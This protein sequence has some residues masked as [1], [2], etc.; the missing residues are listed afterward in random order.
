MV[1]TAAKITIDK[2]ILF[3]YQVVLSLNDPAPTNGEHIGVQF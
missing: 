1:N 3:E 2:T